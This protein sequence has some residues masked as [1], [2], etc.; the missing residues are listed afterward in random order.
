MWITSRFWGKWELKGH[1]YSQLDRNSWKFQCQIKAFKA[2]K[3]KMITEVF[4]F[5]SQW[6]VSAKVSSGHGLWQCKTKLR[7]RRNAFYTGRQAKK[8]DEKHIRMSEGRCRGRK[9]P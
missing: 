2:W 8:E 4:S 9:T 6:E 5:W 7:Q 3:E 1:L